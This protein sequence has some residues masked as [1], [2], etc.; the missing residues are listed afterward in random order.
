[1]SKRLIHI[2]Q[3]AIALRTN[4]RLSLTEICKRLNQPKGTVYYWIKDIPIRIPKAVG[5]LAL[6]NKASTAKYARLRKEAYEAARELAPQLLTDQQIRDFV[7]L[8]LAE[9]TRKL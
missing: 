9:G 4:E 8:Y 1:M 7:V 6:G 2:Q 5:N 3:K